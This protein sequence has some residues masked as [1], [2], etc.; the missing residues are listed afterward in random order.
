MLLT[1]NINKVIRPTTSI[2]KHHESHF[3]RYSALTPVSP[4]IFLPTSASAKL[5]LL[6]Q[7][8]NQSSIYARLIDELTSWR[9]RLRRKPLI[10]GCEGSIRRR[11]H[12]ISGGRGVEGGGTRIRRWRLL[13]GRT[14]IPFSLF[15]PEFRSL[16]TQDLQGRTRRNLHG[17]PCDNI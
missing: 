14:V 10:S 1:I 6:H 4:K 3:C 11:W 9:Y 7:T 5:Y 13:R 16:T 15:S 2:S 12:G 17:Q 8:T